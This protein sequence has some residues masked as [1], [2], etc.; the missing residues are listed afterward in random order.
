MDDKQHVAVIDI[1]KTNVKLAL[2][3]LESLAEVAVLTQSN[4]VLPGPPY[5]HFDV[6]CLWNFIVTGLSQFQ[7]METISAIT[8]T[9]HGA[10][11]VLLDGEGRLAAPI[12]DYEHDGP[13]GLAAKYDDVRPDFEESGSPRLPVGLNLGAQIFWLFETFPDTKAKTRFVVTYPQYWVARLT[14]IVRNEVTSLG[15]HTDLWCPKKG[16]YSTMVD[17]LGWLA[18][19]PRLCRPNECIGP[20][21]TAVAEQTGLS[22]QTSVYG[23]IHDSN[24][25]LY[26]HLLNRASPFSVVSTGTWVVCM[27]IGGKPVTLDPTRDTLINVNGFGQPVLS[28]RF[29]GG[30]EFEMLMGEKSQLFQL[31]E[32]KRVLEEKL[33]LMPS[34]EPGSGP[35]QGRK[36]R[37]I[38]GQQTWSDGE[39]FVAASFYLALMT[40]TCLDLIGAAGETIVEGPF[41]KN[42]L[43]CDMLAAAT[44][45][46]VI[47]TSGTGTSAGAALL[48]AAGQTSE[49]LITATTVTGTPKHSVYANIWRSF[50]D[51]SKS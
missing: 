11:A 38:E 41:S 50:V 27:A 29:M 17:R 33:M 48:T 22:K 36:H 45:G 8:V 10:S 37:W 7:I 26:P 18:L 16:C 44:G 42:A 4:P 28:S 32:V 25:S 15:C 35:Y 19:M 1:G 49:S 14:G 2:I 13:D 51:A 24:A 3:E 21:H 30:R 20:I 9:T 47:A 39:R 40:A 5:P 43:F 46:Q 31:D 23:G 34:V 6:E 12:L